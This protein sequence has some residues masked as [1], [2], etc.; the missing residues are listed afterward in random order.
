MAGVEVAARRALGRAS[1]SASARV[2]PARSRHAARAARRPP[3]AAARISSKRLTRERP[4]ADDGERPGQHLDARRQPAER[5]AVDLD[6][7][8]VRAS[9]RGLDGTP[10]RAGDAPGRRDGCRGRARELGQQAEL[11]RSPGSRRRRGAR[12]RG[13]PRG[14]TCMPPPNKRP[15]AAAAST[16]GPS[17]TS[18]PSTR[19]ATGAAARS[20]RCSRSVPIRNDEPAAERLRRAVH[21]LGREAADAE[22]RDVHEVGDGVAR[23]RGRRTTTRP[24]SIGGALAGARSP[25]ARR[26]DRAGTPSVRAK[27]AARAER[28]QRELRVVAEPGA[29]GGRVTT[30]LTVPSPPATTTRS[31][32]ARTP[33]RAMRSASR[34]PAR[35]A[36]RRSR[37]A[38]RARAA[39]ARSKRRRAAPPPLA[40]FT[41]TRVRRGTAPETTG[42]R[43]ARRVRPAEADQR[44]D[45]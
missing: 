36:R 8:R 37:R 4:A 10:R 12:R 7:G 20:S 26:R 25:R 35:P 42:A 2:P 28:Q 16:S 38:P 43:R 21:E 9:R 41:T 22:A 32:P 34:G 17:W 33:S 44:A 27:V 3:R 30:S 23:R 6:P 19:S 45:S 29:R 40:G 5:L 15:F 18:S 14:A 31:T 39:S 24:A 1:A 11:R 13:A